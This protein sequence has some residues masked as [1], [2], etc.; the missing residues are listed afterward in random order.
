MLEPC[1]RSRRVCTGAKKMVQDL[2]DLCSCCYFDYHGTGAACMV[3]STSL[4]WIVQECS[5]VASTSSGSPFPKPQNPNECVL[6]LN[7]HG[8]EYE[9][10]F[11]SLRRVKILMAFIFL[12]FI[13]EV[14]QQGSA[15]LLHLTSFHS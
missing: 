12:V 3:I 8:F 14:L 1:D 7:G 4:Q 9:T 6:L 11:F 2:N 13:F 15:I 5:T 10:K